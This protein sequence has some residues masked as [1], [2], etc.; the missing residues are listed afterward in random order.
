MLTRVVITGIGVVTPIGTGIEEF[1]NASLQGRSGVD[2]ITAFDPSLFTT[3]IAAEIKS[4]TPTLFIPTE[5]L[6]KVERVY[7]L[8]L[9]AAHLAVENSGLDF[10]Q[11]DGTRIGTCAGSCVGGM[12]VPEVQLT[13]LYHND[14]KKSFIPI[15]ESK[16]LGN[17]LSDFLNIRGPTITL[18]NAC[19][20]GNHAIGWAFNLLRTGKADVVVAGGAEAP[21]LP[22]LTAGF[23]SLRVMSQRNNEPQRASRPFDLKRD[24]FVLGEGAAILILETLDH[25]RKRSVPIYAEVIG[26]SMVG[27]AYHM[28]M[29]DPKAGEQV[30]AMKNA[31]VDASVNYSEV[32]YINAHGTSTKR[33]DI[34][35]TRAIKALFGSRAY[36]IPI[37]ATKSMLG[38][39]IGAAGAIELAVCA[40]AIRDNLIPPTINYE[41]PDPECDLDYV[42]NIA[43]ERKVNITLCNSFGFGGNNSSIVLR[44]IDG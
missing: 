28:V 11:E 44:K 10:N 5:R 18:S 39:T 29:P 19:S 26:Y 40:L 36:K 6:H 7:Q 21:I 37:S 4:F 33:N 23:C 31:L 32:D 24:G 25:A 30:N 9:V 3:K 20:T 8:G 27:E 16:P 14:R 13:A 42:P 41:V 38:H 1:W 17:H 43:R 15:P 34:G 22:L 35:E 2:R 12:L